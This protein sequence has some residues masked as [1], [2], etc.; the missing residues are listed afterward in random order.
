[1]KFQTLL[2]VV[3]C[4]VLTCLS[5]GYSTECKECCGTLLSEEYREQIERMIDNGTWDDYT[6]RE[7]DGVRGTT[8]VRTTF[9]ILRNINGSNGMPS[10][11]CQMQLDYLNSH[12]GDTGLQFCIQDII[13][14]DLDDPSVTY[15]SSPSYGFDPNSMNVYCTPNIEYSFSLCGYASYPYGTTFV[16]QNNCMGPGTTTFSHEAGHYF[17]LP[18]TFEGTENGNNPECVDGSNCNSAGDYFCD[19]AADDNGGWAW[20]CNYT[21]GGVDVCNG[22]PY[23]PNDDNLMSYG[24]DSCTDE[25]TPNQL[26]AYLSTAEIYRANILSD[27]P[28]VPN[29]GACCNESDS[30]LITYESMCESVGWIWQGQGTICADGCLQNADGACCVGTYCL[31]LPESNCNAGG[32]VWQGPNTTCVEG[33]CTQE[34]C[35]GDLNGDD[36]VNVNDLLEVVEQWGNSS[37]SG[38]INEDGIVDVGDLLLIVEGWGDCP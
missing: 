33:I 28:C 14:H 6:N 36:V 22:D 12:V 35:E 3:A 32:G 24:P 16:V 1:M 2:T 8:Y 21:G 9:H 5:T 29:T 34:P 23:N 19:T 4:S 13:Y 10:S 20:N 17:G 27:E 25:F 11:Y 37:G 30:C 7:F 26:S 38:D 18:H 31:V 15:P